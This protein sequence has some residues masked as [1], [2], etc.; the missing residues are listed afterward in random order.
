M[1]SSSSSCFLRGSFVFLFI[2]LQLLSL[3]GA[4]IIPLRV[5]HERSLRNSVS[6]DGKSLIFY[7][8]AMELNKGMFGCIYF[9]INH[10]TLKCLI[11]ALSR[12]MPRPK[13]F[14]FWYE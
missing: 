7:P 4:F 3:G 9:D 2:G 1:P 6:D 11:F 5:R 8:E 13:R 12:S 10:L 14:R